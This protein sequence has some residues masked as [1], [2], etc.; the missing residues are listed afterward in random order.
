[1]R[2]LVFQHV[3]V[4]HPGVFR[5]LW[6]EEG[7][8]W[9]AVE[10]DA[11]DPIPDL[12][13]YDV[14]VVMGGPMDVWE[15]DAHPWLVPE[16]AAIRRWLTE[17]KRP[18][19]GICFGHQLLAV[20]LDGAVGP[21]NDEVGFAPVSFTEAGRHDPIFAGFGAGMETFQWHSA[22]VS[23]LPTGAVILAENSKCGVQAMRVG[24]TAYGLQYHVELTDRTVPEWG[25]IPAYA[26]SLQKAL[27]AEKAATLE[28]DTAEKLPAF[29]AAARRLHENFMAII[30]TAT[31]AAS[32]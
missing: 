27:G 29:N 6:R 24:A 18:Y 20:A 1:M 14:L 8:E 3:D 25:S 16:K 12:A 17:L 28:P 10:L 9:D 13:D 2:F 7:I 22:E 4:E 21:G 31:A 23:Q 5:D 11:G 32:E 19:L 15:E 30:A 26:A